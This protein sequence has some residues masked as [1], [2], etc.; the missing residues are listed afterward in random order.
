M[1]GIVRELLM[2]NIEGIFK[3]IK[4]K[5]RKQD[6]KCY[7]DPIR[8]FL[9]QKTP[10]EEVRQKT[11]IFL[12]NKLGVPIERIRVE[13]PMCH[14][15]KG[16]RGRADIV[17]YRDD[18]QEEPLMVIECKA[19]YIDV[20]CNMVLDQ[21]V[22]YRNILGAEYIMLI[23]GVNAVVYQ[24][25]NGRYKEIDKVPSYQELLKSKVKIIKQSKDKPYTFEDIKS[26]RLQNNFLDMGYIGEDSP[27]ENYEFYLNLLNLLLLKK[28]SSS[29]ILNRIGVIEDCFRGFTF[30]GNRG[31]GTY[32][33]WTRLFIAQDHEGKDQVLG[34]SICATA[35][36]END[37]HWGTSIG[38]TQ[39]NISIT[40]KETRHHSL[41][42][43]LDKF[44]E[45]DVNTNMVKVTHNGS[46]TR[47]RDGALPRSA[48]I[49][50]V[51]KRAPE[52]VK[53]N[54]IHLGCLD[55]SRLLEWRNPNVQSF[56]RNL[57]RYAVLRDG[58]RA[59]YKRSK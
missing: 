46:I 12:Q 2:K 7:F 28:I 34:I 23:N 10:E 37:P 30:F 13:E 41:Q 24:F 55:S 38:R 27:K 21:A 48:L 59:E 18:K 8:Y 42:L 58:F 40:N 35:H 25:K 16:L 51:Q 26:K 33:T 1:C 50:Y 36:T 19:P 3:S 5:E 39:L 56:I 15:K 31:G 17:V 44:C 54:K 22:R 49:D 52:L 14:V 11:I 9:V 4:L 6:G 29:N 47:G 43:N 53:D 32:Q 20:D 57:L 45:F